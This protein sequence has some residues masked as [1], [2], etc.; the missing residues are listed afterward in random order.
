MF[1]NRCILAEFERA[2]FRLMLWCYTKFNTYNLISSTPNQT[3]LLIK[4]NERKIIKNVLK[5][6]DIAA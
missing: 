6:V 2:E 5:V 3:Y 1:T 4:K